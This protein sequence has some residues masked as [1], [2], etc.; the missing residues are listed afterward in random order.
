MLDLLLNRPRSLRIRSS[1]LGNW[2]LGLEG[3]LDCARLFWERTNLECL[4][5]VPSL[6][7]LGL[8][9]RARGGAALLVERS[10]NEKCVGI[11]ISLLL[12]DW[13]R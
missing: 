9:N 1:S 8:W 2:N 4:W 6:E 5:V 10:E 11:G 12:G 7:R 3:S 13:R